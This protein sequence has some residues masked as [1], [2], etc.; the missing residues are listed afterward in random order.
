MAKLGFEALARPATVLC[1]GAHCDD[2]EIGCAGTLVRWSRQ[3]PEMRFIWA[4][5]AREDGRDRESR[6]AAQQLFD[7]IDRHELRFFDFRGSYF[8]AQ[9]AAIKDAFEGLKDLR[10]DVVLTHHLHDRHQDHEVLANLTWNTFR[11]NL[12]LEYEIPKFEGDLGHPNVYVPLEPLDL[13]RKVDVLMNCFPSQRHRT[14]FTAD[15]FRALARLRGIESAAPSG[16][17]EAFHGRKLWM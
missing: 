10:P 12:V 4:I 5:F 16:F 8:P 6:A 3:Y 17:A 11:S 15:T 13:D 7:A 9:F 1:V 14:W 2:I